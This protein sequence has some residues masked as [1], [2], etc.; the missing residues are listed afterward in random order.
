[1]IQFFY[2]GASKTISTQTLPSKS[3]GGIVS[4]SQ[5]P[6]N[7]ISSIFGSLPR[8]PELGYESEFI[9]LAMKNVSGS[10][11]TNLQIW[12][13]S[14][15]ATAFEIAVVSVVEDS[16]CPGVFY[17]EEVPDRYSQP[18]T[19]N[20]VDYNATSKGTIASFT[21]GSYLG[22][23]IKRISSGAAM[24]SCENLVAAYELDNSVKSITE[25]IEEFSLNLEY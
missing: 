22:V 3:I 9:G 11:I 23:W 8:S 19:G 7:R 25:S 24:D 10:D 21:N 20:F 2:T 13:E 4:T 5:V 1:M 18:M 15:A 14:P 17:I 12:I 16:N 6:N